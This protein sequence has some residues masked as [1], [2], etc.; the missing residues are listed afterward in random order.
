MRNCEQ[1]ASGNYDETANEAGRELMFRPGSASVGHRATPPLLGRESRTAMA[2]L[3]DARGGGI[4]AHVTCFA[5]S[6][7]ILSKTYPTE[8]Q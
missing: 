1:A 5:A 3:E 2:R 4:L 7:A 8:R 6:R